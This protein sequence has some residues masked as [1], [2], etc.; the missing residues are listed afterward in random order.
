MHSE[1]INDISYYYFLEAL[2]KIYYF[3][4]KMSL[5]KIARKIHIKILFKF[6]QIFIEN[7]LEN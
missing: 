3:L 6:I 4:S 2:K 1:N 5:D 7:F